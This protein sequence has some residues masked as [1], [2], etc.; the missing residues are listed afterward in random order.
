ML[1]ACT[2][3]NIVYKS[4]KAGLW[5]VRMCTSLHLGMGSAADV[6]CAQVVY[7]SGN[8]GVVGSG[9]VF[10]WQEWVVLWREMV[11]WEAHRSWLAAASWEQVGK[12]INSSQGPSHRQQHT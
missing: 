4:G 10:A 8:A 1:R 9:Y 3:T 7:G 11:T 2:C 6:S 12:C 5:A